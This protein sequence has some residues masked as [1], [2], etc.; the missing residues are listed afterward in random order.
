MPVAHLTD[1]PVTEKNGRDKEGLQRIKQFALD[2]LSLLTHTNYVLNIQ[3]EATHKTRPRE[4]PCLIVLP[5]DSFNWLS[6]WWWPA[7]AVERHTR[8]KQNRAK[9]QASRGSQRSSSNGSFPH[10]RPSKVRLTDLGGTKSC[11]RRNQ[12]TSV[13]HSSPSISVWQGKCFRICW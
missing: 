6:V 13:S 7:E 2:A 4:R 9:V 11:K 5:A 10:N 1:L 3:E 12:T 8:C